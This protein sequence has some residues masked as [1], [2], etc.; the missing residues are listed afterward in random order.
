MEC[1][2]G[3]YARDGKMESPGGVTT[4][5]ARRVDVIQT[6]SPKYTQVSS[7]KAS[8]PAYDQTCGG[9]DQTSHAY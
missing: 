4:V 2:N 6:W 3:I 8:D 5:P 1:E 7:S 9:R